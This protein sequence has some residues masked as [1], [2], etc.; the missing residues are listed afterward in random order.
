MSNYPFTYPVDRQVVDLDGLRGILD[1]FEDAWAKQ[2]R[3]RITS[4]QFY[5][6]Y[7]AGELDT[8]FFMAFLAGL[9]L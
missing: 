9:L 3:D 2:G 7:S 1:A 5:D 8:M 4:A 6:R